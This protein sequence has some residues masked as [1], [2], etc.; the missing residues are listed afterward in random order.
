MLFNKMIGVGV[1]LA[2]ILSTNSVTPGALD[3]RVKETYTN[4]PTSLENLDDSVI[5]PMELHIIEPDTFSG[6][7][8]YERSFTF[9][10]ENGEDADLWIHNTS[11]DTI[12]AKV[13][14]GSLS[15]LV[16][17]FEKGK[18]NIIRIGVIGTTSVKV[19]TY[20]STGHKIDMSISARQF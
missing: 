13:T 2:V 9:N 19:N 16:V 17:P 8:A 4:P 12:Y 14:V 15:P 18:Q 20:S 3:D 1:A 10:P 7:S 11:S 6:Y 5:T